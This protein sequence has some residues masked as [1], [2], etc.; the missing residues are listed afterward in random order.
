MHK[1]LE[2][3]RTIPERGDELKRAM[4]AAQKTVPIPSGAGELSR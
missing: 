4:F 3:K 2:D 1:E